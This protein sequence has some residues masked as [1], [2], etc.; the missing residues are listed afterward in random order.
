M[1]TFPVHDGDHGRQVPGRRY[2]R[3]F[4][5]L[6]MSTVGLVAMTV[7]IVGLAPDTPTQGDFGDPAAPGQRTAVASATPTRSEAPTS[8]PA[9]APQIAPDLAEALI[10]PVLH[11]QARVEPVDSREGQL[12][13]PDNAADVGWWTGGA[14]PG[15]S[16]GTIVMAGHVDSAATGPGALFQLA[17]LR[18][19]D[20]II[21][22]LRDRQQLTY[23]VNARR[24]YNKITGLPAEMFTQTGPARLVLITCGGP[25]DKT[26]RSYRDN[27]VVFAVPARS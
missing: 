21:V 1:S 20:N 27:I 18:P 6:A 26:T 3:W 24:I 10:I 4:V 8:E 14:L 16:S 23:T 17:T 11:V 19:G 7:A 12:E 2:R 22:V 9:P 25:F 13:L 15:S 5:P